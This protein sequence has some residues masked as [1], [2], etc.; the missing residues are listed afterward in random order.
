MILHNKIKG[1]F[2]C[3]PLE[4]M[5]VK[6][7]AKLSNSTPEEIQP[8]IDQLLKDGLIKGKRKYKL[9]KVPKWVKS[10]PSK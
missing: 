10:I 1:L 6:W 3:L 5:D 7:L 4:S 8:I 2:K 9:K